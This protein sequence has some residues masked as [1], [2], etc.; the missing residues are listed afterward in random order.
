MSNPTA[1]PVA[2]PD[3]GTTFE[4]VMPEPFPWYRIVPHPYKAWRSFLYV[5][6]DK[7][8]AMACMFPLHNLP[9]VPEKMWNLS[10][11]SNCPTVT[12]SINCHGGCGRHFSLIAGKIV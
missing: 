10:G 3:R 5:G 12:P 6:C 8:P 7:T 4:T 11:P 1:D 9:P 2:D